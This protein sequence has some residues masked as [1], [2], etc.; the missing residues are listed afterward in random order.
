MGVA[1]ALLAN[2]AGQRERTYQATPR[3]ARRSRRQTKLRLARKEPGFGET[4]LKRNPV[5]KI[6]GPEGAR[7]ERNSA[8]KTTDVQGRCRLETNSRNLSWI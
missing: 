1:I 3:K 8:R 6:P 2:P 4:R 5:Q 7:P